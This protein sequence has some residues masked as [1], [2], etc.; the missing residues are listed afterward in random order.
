MKVSVAIITYNQ[1]R[2][3]AQAVESAINQQTN[4]DF[5]IVI[6]EDCS[7]DNTRVNLM[8]LQTKYPSKIRL[9]LN[10]KKIGMNRNLVRVLDN[11][12]GQYIALLE[13]DDYWTDS[14]KLQK[15]ADYLD[16]HNGSAISFHDVYKL[17]DS[18]NYESWQTPKQKK[19]SYRLEDLLRGNFIPTC[20]V[21]FRSGLFDDFPNWYYQTPMGDWPLHVLNAHHGDIGYIDENMAVYR[22]HATSNWSSNSRIRIRQNTLTAAKLIKGDLVAEHSL[23]LNDSIIKW[24][25]NLVGM[26]FANR[27]FCRGIE[28]A[29]KY[30]HENSIPGIVVFWYWLKS[31]VLGYSPK[32]I[33][34]QYMALKG[35]LKSKFCFV[36]NW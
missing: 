34:Q 7:T 2:F 14:N 9:L 13:G 10:E 32:K 4:F 15:Q 25:Q 23:L 16:S 24:E 36:L 29:R 5:E 8:K 30:V 31:L 1:E 6:G 28:Y 27:E 35:K 12:D 17:M 3:I 11:S 20:S 21:M 26:L 33:S 22:L 18:G 19:G